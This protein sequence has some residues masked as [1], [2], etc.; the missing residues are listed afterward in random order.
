MSHPPTMPYPTLWRS[1]P[2]ASPV[3]RAY[4]N[5]WHYYLNTPNWQG[6]GHIYLTRRHRHAFWA[7]YDMAKQAELHHNVIGRRQ[8]DIRYHPAKELY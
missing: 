2:L 3:G 5:G 6:R 1:Y 4:W 8:A 7:G